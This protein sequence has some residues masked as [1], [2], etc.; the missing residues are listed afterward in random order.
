MA[1]YEYEHQKGSCKLGKVFDWDQPM[2][3]KP[4]TAC[5]ECGKP[6]KRLVSAP[7]ITTTRSNSEIRDTGFTKLV[8][9]DHGVYENVTQREGE[10]KIV[11]LD[12]PKTYPLKHI[13]D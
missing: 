1:T 12:D 4:L 6:V 5:P 3:A 13:K 11:N 10:S 2:S 7:T 8:R 9:R